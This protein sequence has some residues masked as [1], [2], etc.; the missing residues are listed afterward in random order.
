M[1][2]SRSVFPIRHLVSKS[3]TSNVFESC[4]NKNVTVWRFL[5]TQGNRNHPTPNQR[6]NLNSQPTTDLFSGALLSHTPY[7]RGGAIFPGIS[8][9][10]WLAQPIHRLA[11]FSKQPCVLC[12]S[13][14]I[15]L[16]YFSFR[17]YQSTDLE[18]HTSISSSPF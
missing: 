4:G 10:L 1:D 12:A 9:R 14:G 5:V 2:T 18:P 15:V 17:F 6:F 16:K 3:C 11:L 8:Y 13:I 7:I